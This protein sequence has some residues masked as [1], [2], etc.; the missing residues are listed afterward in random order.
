MR[1]ATYFDIITGRNDGNPLY[2]AA[3]LKRRNKP[4]LFESDVLAPN[5]TVYN[6][7]K[8]DLNIWVD[9][10]EDA[11]KD[12]IPYK[13]IECPKPSIYWA[14]D[15]HLGYQHRLE[16]AKKFDHVFVAQKKAVGD[17][18]R[19]GVKAEW[20]PHAFE[21][22]AYDLQEPLIKKYDVCFI[23]HI[24]NEKRIEF[25]DRMFKE[26]PSFWYGQ[27]LFNDAAK[28]FGESKICLNISHSD[29]LNMRTFEVMGTG[30]FLLTEYVPSME[31]LFQD[32]VHLAWY[33]TI[34]EAIDKAKFYLKNEDLRNEIAKKGYQE[35]ILN[36]TIDNRLDRMLQVCEKE[37]LIGA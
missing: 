1:V 2:I 37:L 25:L 15:T 12:L 34:D 7:G 6:H 11:L 19:D 10:G 32:G 33:K 24:N 27:K 28:K 13:M 26:F 30:S 21:P 16:T 17:F 5:D 36:H 29:D 9:W 14:S 22:L 31:E 8:Y 35:V 23:G 18:E 4:G 3:A 20:L